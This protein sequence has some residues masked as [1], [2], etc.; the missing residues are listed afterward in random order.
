M[1]IAVFFPISNFLILPFWF[2]MIVLPHWHWTR[3]IIQSPL[4]V[5]P[6]ALVYAVLVVPRL[7]QLWPILISP[8]ISV[9]AAQLATP[10]GAMIAWA[11]FQAFDLLGG[12]WAYLD[13]RERRIS[14]WF[15]VPILFLMLMF[16]PIGL[17]LYLCLQAFYPLPQPQSAVV[18]S[19]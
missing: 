10:V 8:N 6:S 14:A 15:M 19:S 12:R 3:R 18:T 11:H 9:L 16:G 7:L 17:L 1:T 13:S 4:I 5:V 2:L